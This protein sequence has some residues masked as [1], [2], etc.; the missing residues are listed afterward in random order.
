MKY[1]DFRDRIIE[2]LRRSGEGMTWSELK[3]RLDLPYRTPC[4]E[5]VNRMEREND[6]VREKKIGRPLIWEI[7]KR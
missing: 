4:P 7:R 2:K 5:W 3:D 6:L 1:I